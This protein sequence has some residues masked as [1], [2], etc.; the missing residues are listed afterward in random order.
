MRTYHTTCHLVCVTC[1][2]TY[3]FTSVQTGYLA[4]LCSQMATAFQR[5]PIP[6]S[7]AMQVE[8]LGMR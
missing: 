2:E 8:L 3:Y 7:V 6:N 1:Y 5:A 4:Y